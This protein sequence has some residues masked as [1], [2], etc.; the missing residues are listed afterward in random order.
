[1]LNR[2]NFLAAGAAVLAG[3]RKREAFSGYAFVAN[4]D[5]MAIAAVDLGAFAVA[6]LIHLNGHPTDV[7]SHPTRPSVYAL[8]PENGRVHEI[9]TDHLRFARSV[10]VARSAVT[11]RLSPD[12]N[13]LYVLCAEPAAMVALSPI[14]FQVEWK[15]PLPGIPRDIDVS[16]DGASIIISMADLR[17]FTLID[18][19]ERRARRVNAGGLAGTVR[20]RSDGLLWIAARPTGSALTFF[21]TSSA[22]PMVDLPL[23]VHPEHFCFERGGGQL[24]VTGSG[25][26]A[27]VIV[28]PFLTQVG[29][30]VL[31]GRSPGA[32]A[33]SENLLF[34]ANSESG[35]VTV[36]SLD[37]HRVIAVAPVGASPSCITLTPG[38]QYALV[39]DEGSGDMGVLL[40]PNI[41]HTPARTAALVTMIPVGSKPVSAAVRAI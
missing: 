29:E 10:A 17:E 21:E 13:S 5:G 25:S 33:V 22:R 8:T 26:D 11:I 16:A 18:V 20:F 15:T 41:T 27:V 34:V 4:Q 7:L 3:C 32:M 37:S 12:A 19:Q 24:F 39:L 36:L 6:R 9:H 40:V 14:T 23:A 2:R 38:D 35:D 30:T 28:Y 1:M 31:A